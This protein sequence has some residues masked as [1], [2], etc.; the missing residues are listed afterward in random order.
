MDMSDML[1]LEYTA[2]S[3]RSN[4]RK[5]QHSFT[6]MPSLRNKTTSCS[7]VEGCYSG[8]QITECNT[9]IAI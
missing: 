8:I 7:F 9:G 1:F 5:Q 3:F 2:S 4:D 6:V